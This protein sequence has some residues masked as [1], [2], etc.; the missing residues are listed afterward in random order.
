V[1]FIVGGLLIGLYLG[2]VGVGSVFGAAGSLVL[3][4]LWIFYSAQIFLFGAEFT[5]VRARS[6]GRDIEPGKHTVRRQALGTM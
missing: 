6:Q 5:Q 3:I 2:R 1:L 4:L